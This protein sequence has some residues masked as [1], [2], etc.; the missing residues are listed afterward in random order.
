VDG[1]TGF[2]LFPAKTL[3]KGV[4]ADIIAEDVINP[5]VQETRQMQRHLKLSFCVSEF[6]LTGALFPGDL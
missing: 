2:I 5:Q 3:D 4:H 1:Q 6:G